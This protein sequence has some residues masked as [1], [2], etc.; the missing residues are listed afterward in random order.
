MRPITVSQTGAGSS[1][2]IVPDYYQNPFNI[3]L[4]V[5]AT[6]TV[7]YTVEHTFDDIQTN[8]SPT[9]YPNSSLSSQTTSKDGNYAFAVTGIRIT[10]NSG[11]GTAAMTI[12]QS[13]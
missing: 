3:G 1:R 5:L 10:V 4:G 13:A 11:T 2:W 8:G 12:V 9:V 6:G 7:N